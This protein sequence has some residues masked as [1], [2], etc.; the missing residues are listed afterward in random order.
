LG[1]LVVGVVV[2]DCIITTL[3]LLAKI[4]RRSV[5]T[6]IYL[7]PMRTTKIDRKDLKAR[8]DLMDHK[9]FLLCLYTPASLNT[10][11]LL[12]EHKGKAGSFEGHHLEEQDPPVGPALLVCVKI[13]LLVERRTPLG[14]AV[15]RMIPSPDQTEGIFL[16]AILWLEEV[17]IRQAVPVHAQTPNMLS[18]R[19]IP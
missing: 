4:F 7:L 13:L 9:E 18:P 11:I 10:T 8:K 3:L 17:V 2:V 5:R 15:V 14:W 6:V 12:T 19:Y 16:L 1:V